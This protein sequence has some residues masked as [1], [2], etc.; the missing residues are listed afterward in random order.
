[1]C[2]MLAATALLSHMHLRHQPQ[3]SVVY[4]QTDGTTFNPSR[5]L[6]ICASSAPSLSSSGIFMYYVYLPFEREQN[7]S[8][9][10]GECEGDDLLTRV[11]YHHGFLLHKISSSSYRGL[12]YSPSQP[13]PPC[14]D[15][16]T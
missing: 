5:L 7:S 6:K 12:S 8:E 16:S 1:M 4:I 13:P 15:A 9:T 10:K 11:H 14:F 3:S 2:H